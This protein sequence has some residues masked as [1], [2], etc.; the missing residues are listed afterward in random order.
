MYD[1]LNVLMAMDI[2]TR[3]KKEI[4][5]KGLSTTETKDLEELKVD[6]LLSNNYL[7]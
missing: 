7:M 4:R 6:N 5:W 3:E 2:V 1:V